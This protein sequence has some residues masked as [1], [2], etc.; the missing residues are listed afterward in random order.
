MWSSIKIPDELVDSL[1]SKLMALKPRDWTNDRRKDI[2]GLEPMDCKCLVFGMTNS[3]VTP[4]P[5]VSKNC[6]KFDSIFEDLKAIAGLVPTCLNTDIPKHTRT[7]VP[8]YLHTYTY[9]YTSL[10]ACMHI[11]THAH[12]HANA[13]TYQHMCMHVYRHT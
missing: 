8:T 4:G 6:N 11:H 13:H 1:E 12:I 7:S 2:K 3:P 5:Y 10:Y 9:T